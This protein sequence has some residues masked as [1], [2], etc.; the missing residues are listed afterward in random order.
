VT[1]GTLRSPTWE[2]PRSDHATTGARFVSSIR[3]WSAA[4]AHKVYVSFKTEDM[5]YKAAVTG[6]PNIDYI[7][8]SLTIAIASQ[9]QDYVMQR[10]RSDYLYGSTVTV[11]LIG[12]FSAQQLG[13]SEQYYIKKELQASLYTTQ[14]HGKNGIL[15]VVLPSMQDRVFQGSSNC[16]TCGG[17]HSTV[18]INDSTVISEFSHNYYLP[19]GRCSW[20]EED[21]YCVLTTWASF[22]RDPNGWIDKA[23]E[24]RS[25]P[26][27]GKTKVRP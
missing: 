15:G 22:T 2:R 13:E 24:K 23:H 5:E 25:A 12:E 18:S 27:A 3:K 9:D 20:A 11:F 4:L 17:T 1:G 21:R 10:I 26:I 14:N 16:F 19:H 8:K 6:L 7:D